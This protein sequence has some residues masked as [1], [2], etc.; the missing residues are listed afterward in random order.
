M[1]IKKLRQQRNWSQDQLSKISGLSLRTIQRIESGNKA[2]IESL[3]ALSSVFETS[4]ENLE[5]EIIV[6]DKESAQWNKAPLWVRTIFIGS[7]TIKFKRRDAVIFEI[8]L[9]VVGV[10]FLIS[11]FIY[12]DSYKAGIL[13]KAS[14]GLILSA[15]YMSLKVR[16]GDKYLVW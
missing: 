16:M 10:L 14:I 4:V 2:S 5:Q 12:P 8:F 3:K 13:Q 1:I 7:N 9:L 15:Y 11:S 6:V